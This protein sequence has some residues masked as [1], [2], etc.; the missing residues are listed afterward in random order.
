MDTLF[1]CARCG[2]AYPERV[3][4][5]GH[6]GG[7]ETLSLVAQRPADSLWS[8]VGVLS[9]AEL[10]KRGCTTWASTSYP[11]LKTG[12]NSLIAAYG[13]PG[14]GKSTFASRWLDGIQG[15]V[16]F[17]SI[18]EG[19]SDS[20]IQ[21]L[22]RLEIIRDD[23][24]VAAALS[25]DDVAVAV[26]K[27]TPSAIVVDSLSV[28]TLSVSDLKRLTHFAEVPVLFTLHVTKEG[29]PA[30]PMRIVH[31]ADVVVRVD[32]LCWTVEKSRYTWAVSGE[33]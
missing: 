19:L 4:F 15:A 21:R 31:E 24:Y 8:D 30:G 9:A 13:A 6:C 16:L 14:S 26:E 7:F 12:K 29:D 28:S 25:V 10:L 5:C 3:S 1:A 17:L 11:G 22:R 32:S 33:V 20:L 27:Y 2:A 23:F 18:E